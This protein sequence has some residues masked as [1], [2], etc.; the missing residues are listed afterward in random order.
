ME[1]LMTPDDRRIDPEHVRHIAFLT[2]LA[3]TEAEVQTFSEQLSTIIDYFDLLG[4]ADIEGVPP[5]HQPQ[6]ARGA[7]REDDV[8]PSMARDDFL[9]NA[10]Q[11]EGPY[12]KVSVVSDVGDDRSQGGQDG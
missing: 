4:E 1:P 9:E 11:R 3:L 12:V 5:A 2:R 10:P 8:R 7:L 6:M